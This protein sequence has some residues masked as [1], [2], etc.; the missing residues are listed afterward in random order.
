[1]KNAIAPIL[2]KNKKYL[3]ANFSAAEIAEFAATATAG[4]PAAQIQK[5]ITHYHAVALGQRRRQYAGARPGWNKKISTCAQN[6]INIIPGNCL[7][8]LQAMSSELVHLIVT[9]PPYYNARE[10]SQWPNIN[11]YF[12]DMERI[13]QE[14]YRVLRNH[15]YFVLNIGDITGNDGMTTKSSWGNRRLPLSAHFVVM[16]EKIGFTFVDDFIWDKGEVQSQR[17][18]N[19]PYP[20]YTYPMNCYEH[21]LF[22]AKHEMDTLK[23]PC[24]ICGD[25]NVNGNSYVKAGVKSWECKNPGCTQKSAGFRG[26]RFSLRGIEMNEL[27]TLENQISGELLKKW[28]RDIVRI[29]PVIKINSKGENKKL[30]TA[31]FPEEI[32]EYAVRCLTGRGELVYDPFAGSMTTQIVARRLGRI[33]L[34]SEN[35]EKMLAQLLPQLKANYTVNILP[36]K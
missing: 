4:A 13:F 31:P 23:Y 1:M 29:N 22:F 36:G 11:L 32:P 25:L 26:K 19:P 34:G 12:A 5:F 18:K 20:L 16:M 35:D 24:P 33:G 3:A 15:R 6:K 17:H 2:T 27:K 21:I 8:H 28:R 7:T 10:Y 9:S 14:S 30:H